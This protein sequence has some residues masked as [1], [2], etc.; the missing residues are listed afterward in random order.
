[1]VQDEVLSHRISLVPLN[2]DPSYLEFKSD[3]RDQ[4]TDRNALGFKLDVTCT[5][6]PKPAAVRGTK[7]A[8]PEPEEIYNH[9]IVTS[10]LLTWE[11]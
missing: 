5:R 11:P 7:K 3:A 4:A 1:M 6:K 8:E 10:G 9:S 2:V